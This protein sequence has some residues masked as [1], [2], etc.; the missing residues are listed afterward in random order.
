MLN[1]PLNEVVYWAAFGSTNKSKRRVHCVPLVFR[2][3][4]PVLR[5]EVLISNASCQKNQI[6]VTGLGGRKKRVL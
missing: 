2:K 6:K 4:M 5:R 3:K 1:Q